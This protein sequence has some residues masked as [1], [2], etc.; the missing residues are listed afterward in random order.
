MVNLVGA[1]IDDDYSN[2][3]NAVVLFIMP[4]YPHDLHAALKPWLDFGSRMQIALDVVEGI[5]FL[6]S[7]TELGFCKPEA[8]MTCTIVGIPIHMAP[9]L[10]ASSYDNAV[11]IY[12]FGI[13]FWYICANDT[14]LPGAFDAC[15]NKE[16]LWTAVRKGLRPERLPRFDT[17]C[18]ELMTTCWHGD[19]LQRPLIGDV[20]LRIHLIMKRIGRRPLL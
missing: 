2:G 13:L 20:A 7:L 5:R 8:M 15:Q 9:E 4:R 10:L 14:K 12:T 3:S 18:W 19:P 16:Q 11:D 1:L 17:D 6:H